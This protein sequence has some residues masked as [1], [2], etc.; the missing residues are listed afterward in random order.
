MLV[1]EGGKSVACSSSIISTL[2]IFGGME[3]ALEAPGIV[4]SITSWP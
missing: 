2:P 1:P 3:G 4:Q